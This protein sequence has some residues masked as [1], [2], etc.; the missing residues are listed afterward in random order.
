VALTTQ[1]LPGLGGPTS[2]AKNFPMQKI[3]PFTTFAPN[4]SATTMSNSYTK[5][6]DQ[7][8]KALEAYQSS[9]NQKLLLW[10]ANIAYTTRAPRELIPPY[11]NYLHP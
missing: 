5:E 6:E 4:L 9:K 7:I 10:R 8:S 3:P 2:N 11:T 1:P